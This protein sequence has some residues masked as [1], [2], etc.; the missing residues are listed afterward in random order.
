MASILNTYLKEEKQ[1]NI[2]LCQI[3]GIGKNLSKQIC[4]QLGVNETLCFNKLTESQIEQISQLVNQKYC[5]GVELKQ[6]KRK[7]LQRLI[8]IASYRG[9][10]HIQGL[11]TRGQRTHTNARNARHSNIKS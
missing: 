1:L 4:D 2:A 5:V 10:R 6:N 8:R 9:F 7:T 11:P 3:F